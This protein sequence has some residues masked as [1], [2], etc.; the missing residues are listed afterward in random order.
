MEMHPHPPR[1]LSSP[2]RGTRAGDE[3]TEDKASLPSIGKAAPVFAT[4]RTSSQWTAVT[5]ADVQQQ[6]VWRRVRSSE[7]VTMFMT[8]LWLTLAIQYFLPF[9]LLLPLALIPRVGRFWYR[10]L[11]GA[12][13]RW[14]RISVMLIPFSWCMQPLRINR[15]EGFKD[16]KR[17][18]NALLLSTH[19]SRIDWLIGVYLSCLDEP[20]AQIRTGFVAE[21]TTG[22]M[23]ILGWSRALFGD[24]LVKRAFHKDGPLIEGN[25]KSF[26]KSNT[27][28][29]IFLAPEGFIADPGSEVGEKYIPECEA[30]ME[31]MG[32][33]PL[34]HLLTPRYKGMS[35]FVHHSPDNI[36]SCS[37]SF[38][39][40]PVVDEKSSAVV[41]GHLCTRRLRDAGRVIPDLHSVFRG[42]LGVFIRYHRLDFSGGAAH[43]PQRIKRILVEDQMV[44]DAELRH[45]EQHGRYDNDEA[46]VT[47][48]CPH[49]KFHLITLV[50]TVLTLACWTSATGI[51]VQQAITRVATTCT[52]IFVAHATSHYL[53]RWLTS[54]ISRESLVGETAIKAVL[55][56]IAI[57]ASALSRLAGRL[58]ASFKM[59]DVTFSKAI[60][61]A[62]A[63][64]KRVI[65]DKENVQAKAF[66]RAAVVEA[67]AAASPVH[68]KAD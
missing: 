9:L 22:L 27:T 29:L 46:P 58:H 20:A 52:F 66:G 35:A 8:A 34:T 48:H 28:R 65:T 39:D 17:R 51:T 33:R 64:C 40:Y 62:G 6:S 42:G 50:H 49:V 7:P 4:T 5:A 63:S 26:H 3:T 21:L 38:V 59:H 30:F 25:I 15:H 57:A 61:T 55:H 18:G 67:P 11:I 54:D 47:V 19:C 16:M 41:G 43:D 2:A 56:Y 44:K 32:K 45:F 13:D 68:D 1:R 10:R 14:G 60:P 53:V 24:I 23:P 36:G 37:M 31:S 12:Y